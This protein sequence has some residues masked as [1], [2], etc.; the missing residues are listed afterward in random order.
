V[1]QLNPDALAHALEPPAEAH[2]RLLGGN[3]VAIYHGLYGFNR[4]CALSPC[5][6]CSSS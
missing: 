2:G 3:S 6:A 5:A 1:L 4:C